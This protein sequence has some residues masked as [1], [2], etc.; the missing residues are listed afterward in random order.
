MEKPCRRERGFREQRQAGEP[1]WPHDT[2]PEVD[3]VAEIAGGRRSVPVD[4]DEEVVSKGVDSELANDGDF[5]NV[6]FPHGLAIEGVSK[7]VVG[8]LDG[9]RDQIGRE[10]D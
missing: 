1:R 7:G 3:D 4:E 9:A 5:I 6:E 10:L 8:A 2:A